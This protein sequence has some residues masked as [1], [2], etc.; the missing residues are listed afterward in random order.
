MTQ[1]R[2]AEEKDR[3]LLFNVFQKFLHEMTAY[4]DNPLN[5]EGNYEYGWLDSYFED[6]DREA[7]LIYEEDRLAGFALLNKVSYLNRNPDHVMAEFTVFPHFRRHHTGLRAV[8]QLFALYPGTWELKYSRKNTGAVKFW[9]A[10]T[11]PYHPVRHRYG[12]D[13]TVLTFDT[14]V[15]HAH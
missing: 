1:L 8:R 2:K 15:H 4:Y 10:V 5:A 11:K 9:N 14:E 3:Q 13:E 12:T 6:P 7:V